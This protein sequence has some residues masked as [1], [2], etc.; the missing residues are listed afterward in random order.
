MVIYTIYDWGTPSLNYFPF[1][2]LNKSVSNVQNCELI[3]WFHFVDFRCKFNAF[4]LHNLFKKKKK[5]MI[6]SLAITWIL[7]IQILSSQLM[8]YLFIF[9]IFLYRKIEKLWSPPI[10]IHLM[11]INTRFDLFT[12]LKLVGFFLLNKE[13]YLRI[14]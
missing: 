11:F 2:P 14:F 12:I 7:T 4:I 10:F 5:W 9:L 8:G 3:N 13:Y 1:T 6:S